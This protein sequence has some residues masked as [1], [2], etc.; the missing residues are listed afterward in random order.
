MGVGSIMKFLIRLFVSDLTSPVIALLNKLGQISGE[1][2]DSDIGGDPRSSERLFYAFMIT[3]KALLGLKLSL[4]Q[5]NIE[6]DAGRLRAA[7]GAGSGTMPQSIIPAATKAEYDYVR[8][9]CLRD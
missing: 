2:G 8:S 7:L 1:D 5:T 4:W 6:A 3:S 9:S